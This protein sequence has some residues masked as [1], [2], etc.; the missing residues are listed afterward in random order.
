MY[1]TLPLA[2]AF[3]LIWYRR[4][5]V[6]CD[7]GGRK[8]IARSKSLQN[9]CKDEIIGHNKRYDLKHSL[10]VPIGRSPTKADQTSPS[11]NNSPFDIRLGKSAPI[12]ITPNKLSPLRNK[13]NGKQPIDED[14][15]K[16]KSKGID[17]K[18]LNSIE[19]HSFESVDLPSSIGCRRR[20]SFTIK[21]Q[22]P[23]IVVK[24]SNMADSKSPQSSFEDVPVTSPDG[25]RKSINKNN[26]KVDKLEKRHSGT[27][28]AEPKMKSEQKNSANNNNNNT[29]NNNNTHNNIITATFQTNKNQQAHNLSISSPPLSLC[30]NKSHESGD[31]GKGSSPPNSEGGQ[32]LSSIIAYDFEMS[33]NYI[34]YLVGKG[35]SHVQNIKE[36]CG[37]SILVRRHPESKKYK[38][39]TVEGTQKQIDEAL[40]IIRSK[41]PQRIIIKRYVYDEDT[42][43]RKVMP[44]STID[45]S[46][47]QVSY[48]F[49]FMFF[50]FLLLARNNS[51]ILIDLLIKCVIA[52]LSSIIFS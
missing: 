24:A 15:S 28:K 38:L 1:L 4:R 10:S 9:D 49:L 16:N 48:S 11:N 34:G 14:D 47:L 5:K 43:K 39:C 50:F 52:S 30:S 18:G 29:S 19:E 13:V 2:L 7:T 20:F 25:D 35:G 21:S 23:A 37:A 46:L 6:H 51:K 8:D 31:S 3:G 45:S 17:S 12:D 32:P 42:S 40:A 44:T 33:Q 36:K 22:E 41:M 26:A 27:T